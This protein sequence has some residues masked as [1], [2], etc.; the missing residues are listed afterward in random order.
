M[1]TSNEGHQALYNS[2]GKSLIEIFTAG[3]KALASAATTAS[4][5]ASTTSVVSTP[6]EAAQAA[7]SPNEHPIERKRPH[8]RLTC[9]LTLSASK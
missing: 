1:D 3:E 7:P 2:S 4:T 9:A 5:N 8:A 6:A